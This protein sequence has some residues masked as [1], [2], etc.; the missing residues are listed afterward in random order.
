MSYD[1]DSSKYSEISHVT[2]RAAALQRLSEFIERV[3]HYGSQRNFDRIGHPDVSRLSAWIR[4]RVVT[5]EECIASVL[6]AHSFEVAEKFIQEVM[7]RTY[8]KGWLELRPQVWREYSSALGDLQREYS[9]N[10]SYRAAIS[11]STDRT[12]F[13]DWVRELIETGYLHNHTRMWFASV[14][15]FTLEL[16]WQLGA[17]FMYR[18]LIDGDPAS[19]TL[20]WRWVGGLQTKGKFY[21]ARPD[22]IEKYSEGRWRPKPADLALEPRPLPSDSIGPLHPLENVHPVEL[23]EGSCILVH[24]DDLSIDRAPETQ[25]ERRTF[26]VLRRRLSERAERVGGFVEQIREDARKRMD[27][28]FVSDPDEIAA[29]VRERGRRGLFM[30]TPRCGEETGLLA[31]LTAELESRGIKVNRLRREWA[32]RYFPL[33]E[34]GFFPFWNGVKRTLR[35]GGRAT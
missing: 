2:S 12:F 25:V 22:N 9:T 26:L 31:G 4:Y 6:A 28:V 24:D 1:G 7:W 17:E 16:P 13:N 35:R 8:W 15:I 27:G 10:P 30:V 20:S 19:N 3:P 5:E 21:V 33:A 29:A 34:A 18:H 32:C 14:W 11:G 23:E